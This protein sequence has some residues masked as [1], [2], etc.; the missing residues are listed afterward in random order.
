MAEG[1]NNHCAFCIIPKI[2]GKQVSLPIKQVIENAKNLIQQG[3]KELILI[4][5][6]S[7]RY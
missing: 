5:Q 6:D 7:T 4:A 3:A 1:C 2:R